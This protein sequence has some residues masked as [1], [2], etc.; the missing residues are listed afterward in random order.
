[1]PGFYVLDSEINKDSVEK[2]FR[3]LDQNTLETFYIDSHGGICEYTQ[4]LT[5]ALNSLRVK[6]KAISL[7]SSAF[8]LFYNCTE[9]SREIMPYSH[10]MIHMACY[11]I[12]HNENGRETKGHARFVK[13]KYLKHTGLLIDK[14]F[15]SIGFEISQAYNEGEEIYFDRDE[16]QQFLDFQNANK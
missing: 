9:C 1:M 10:G 12:Q 5:D 4:I 6:V 7:E 2:F 11:D 14:L 13:D 16:L 15:K 8:E 3:W